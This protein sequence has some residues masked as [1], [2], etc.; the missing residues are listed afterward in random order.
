MNLSIKDNIV[1]GRP[2]DEERYSTV[3]NA[4]ALLR[5]IAMLPYGDESFAGLRGMNLSGGQ[6]QRVNV[7]RCAYFGADT[8]LLDGALSAVDHTTAEHIFSNCVEG[9]FKDKAVVLVT[10]LLCV[11]P[12]AS[13]LTYFPISFR[14]NRWILPINYDRVSRSRSKID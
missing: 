11:R 4:C 6:R 1:F 13:R 2:F 9:L 12:L 7:A 3:L 10:H 14:K 5:D 8:I